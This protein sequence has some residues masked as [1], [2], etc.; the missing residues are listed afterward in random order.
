MLGVESAVVLDELLEA[1]IDPIA[2]R[3]E[4]AST[5]ADP[6]FRAGLRVG[7]R[8]RKLES[9][10][11]VRHAV[12]SL[13]RTSGSVERRGVMGSKEFLQS[14][15]SRNRPVVLAGLARAWPAFTT[16]SADHLSRTCGDEVVEVM[17]GREGDPRYELNSDAHKTPMRLADYVDRVIEGTPGNDLYLVANN[18]FLEL[19]GARCLLDDLDPLPEFLDS[20]RICG[21]AYLWF[22]PAGTVTPLHH[23]T[24]NVLLTQVSGRK[25]V[26]L[27]PAAQTPL[28]YNDVAVYS[29]VD[30]ENPGANHP[31]FRRADRIEF[32]LDPGDGLFVPVGWWHLV[33]AVDLS[34]S[35]SFTNFAFPNEFHWFHPHVGS[36]SS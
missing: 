18:K 12:E 25:K 15:Y 2:G 27:V 28:V 36:G 24:M 7:Q 20:D 19:P 3:K 29:E 22:G 13:A 1:G 32:I 34:I 8:L 5:I 9:V 26:V 35:V 23:D 17:S 11:A 4:I 14:Y 30:G 6:R 33:R 21:S 10:L 31:L 16:W